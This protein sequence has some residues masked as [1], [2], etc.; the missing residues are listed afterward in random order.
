MAISNL[1]FLVGRCEKH[2]LS[3]I[4]RAV[5]RTWKNRRCAQEWRRVL[6]IPH[7]KEAWESGQILFQD[8]LDRAKSGHEDMEYFSMIEFATVC[9]ADVFASRVY[10]GNT[11]LRNLA[12]NGYMLAWRGHFLKDLDGEESTKAGL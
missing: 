10:P 4:T 8:A 5:E 9:Y 1:L 2:F 7:I 12:I 6:Q 11:M 3:T